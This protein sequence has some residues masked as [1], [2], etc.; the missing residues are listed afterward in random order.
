MSNVHVKIYDRNT[1]IDYLWDL[2]IH[3][4]DP[5]WWWW[6]WWLQWLF[7]F[8]IVSESTISCILRLDLDLASLRWCLVF[9]H[10]V[11]FCFLS[12]ANS[13]SRVTFSLCLNRRKGHEVVRCTWEILILNIYI[14]LLVIKR[15]PCLILCLIMI[16][17]YEHA[18]KM[19]AIIHW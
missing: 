19:H 4:T 14:H 11:L 8:A 6:T 7:E 15:L 12:S 16:I 2:W 9:S 17:L 3:Y 10:S 13:H 1:I 5:R 18:R